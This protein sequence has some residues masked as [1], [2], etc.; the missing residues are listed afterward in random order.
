M[1]SFPYRTPALSVRQPFGVFYVTA[2]PAALLLEV[3]FSD[4]A[5]VEEAGMS[6]YRVAGTQRK[7]HIERWRE[8]GEFIDTTEAVFP[9][10]IVL[11][12]NY[13][14]DGTLEEGPSRWRVERESGAYLV[15]PSAEKLASVVDGQHRLWA[16]NYAEGEDRSDMPLV[17]SVFFDLPNPYQAYLFATVNFNQKK[18]ERSLVYELFGFATEDDPPEAWTPEKTAVFLTRR[19]NMDPESPLRGRIVVA[20]QDE[21]GLTRGEGTVAWSV[22]TATVVDGLLRLFSRKPKGDRS[23]M[24]GKAR[25]RRRRRDLEDDGTPARGMYRKT[26]D[27]AIYALASNFLAAVEKVFWRSADGRSSLTRTVGIQAWFDIMFMV[28]G[29]AI[30]KGQLGIGYFVDIV[31]GARGLDFADSFFETSGKGRTRI[32]N[33]L[34]VAMGLTT[35]EVLPE[36]DREQYAEI[37]RR[38]DEM[39]ESR[40]G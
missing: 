2:L 24:F 3:G 4:L 40:D 28:A 23:T 30:R 5:R 34:A 36:G 39:Q 18:V 17:C 21:E 38:R 15:I 16:F 26:N 32:K 1:Y 27:M 31:E 8:I 9:T 37:I 22:S 13:R 35:L 6:G 11:A 10:S 25:G 14:E 19:L 33:T 7:Q 12:A 20:A 29:S